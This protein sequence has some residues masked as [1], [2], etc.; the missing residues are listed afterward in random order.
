[1]EGESKDEGEKIEED[2]EAVEENEGE[3]SAS[4]SESDFSDSESENANDDEDQRF[5]HSSVPCTHQVKII[6][7][8]VIDI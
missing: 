3:S 1:M 4:D 7:I 5:F 2:Q 6:L 8:F